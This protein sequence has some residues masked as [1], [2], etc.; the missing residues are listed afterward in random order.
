[1]L[2]A[3]SPA[4]RRDWAG[5]RC[6]QAQFS[7]RADSVPVRSQWCVRVGDSFK[8]SVTLRECAGSAGGTREALYAAMVGGLGEELQHQ[9][10]EKT[11]QQIRTRPRGEARPDLHLLRSFRLRLLLTS[12]WWTS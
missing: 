7:D 5:N 3:R 12:A 2:P 1:M 8:Y 10:T 9:L 11:W 4:K 6:L